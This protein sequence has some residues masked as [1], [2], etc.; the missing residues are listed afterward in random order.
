MQQRGDDALVVHAH[1][2]EDARDRD[3]VE[4]VGFAGGALLPFVGLGAE[5]VGAIDLGHLGAVEI[6][7]EIVAEIADQV[8]LLFLVG[9]FVDGGTGVGIGLRIRFGGCEGVFRIRHGDPS[10]CRERRFPGCSG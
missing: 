1:L 6:I 9:A 4:D 5:Q 8:A 10:S 2:A 7:L 3:G